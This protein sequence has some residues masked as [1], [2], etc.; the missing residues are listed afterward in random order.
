MNG[1]HPT[2]PLIPEGADPTSEEKLETTESAIDSR[3]L[4]S[5]ILSLSESGRDPARLRQLRQTLDAHLLQQVN[6]ALA[7]S[8]K[9]D[10]STVLEFEE[11]EKARLQAFKLAITRTD[12][13]IPEALFLHKSNTETM[14]QLRQSLLAQ[15]EAIERRLQPG[16][17]RHS[18]PR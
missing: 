3:N 15:K 6:Q 4:L 1:N 16:K 7:L 5:E 8:H 2:D 11:I 9:R 18:L 12:L 13:T 17:R 14:A 10:P